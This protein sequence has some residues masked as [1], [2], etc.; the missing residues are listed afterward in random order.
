[1]L[2][3][4]IRTLGITTLLVEHHMQLIMNIADTI[5]VLSAGSVIANGPPSAI[6]RHPKVISA[7]LG[8][9]DEPPLHP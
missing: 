4:K 1:V 7:Y 6:Q 2:L 3:Q 5:T 8:Q 9:S